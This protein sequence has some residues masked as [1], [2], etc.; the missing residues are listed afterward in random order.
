MVFINFDKAY[1]MASLER[2]M[3]KMVCVPIIDKY[4]EVLF[5]VKTIR[6]ETN[7]LQIIIRLH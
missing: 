5:S 7:T 4:N 6:G 2:E 3:F 1:N